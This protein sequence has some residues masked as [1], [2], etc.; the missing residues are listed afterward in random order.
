[1]LTLMACAGQK[2]SQDTEIKKGAK[3]ETKKEIE[4]KEQKNEQA[5]AT[6][7]TPKKSE[8]KPLTTAEKCN[9]INSTHEFSAEDIVTPIRN[10]YEEQENVH[11]DCSCIEIVTCDGLDI[12]Y[13]FKCSKSGIIE[14]FK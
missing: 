13:A 11:E 4:L 14:V 8:K 5:Q 9:K 7:K 1:V 12:C 3:K 2:Q 10:S 6:K